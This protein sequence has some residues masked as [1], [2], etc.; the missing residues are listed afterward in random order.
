M[1]IDCALEIDDRLQAFPAGGP[2]VGMYH[3]RGVALGS[4]ILFLWK[5]IN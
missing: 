3:S 1:N 5:L 2:E 4:I